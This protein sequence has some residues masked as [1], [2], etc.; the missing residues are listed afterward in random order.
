MVYDIDNK[1]FKEYFI[2]KNHSNMNGIKSIRFNKKSISVTIDKD[3]VNFFFNDFFTKKSL[4]K[5]IIFYL[6]MYIKENQL[7]CFNTVGVVYDIDYLK[8]VFSNGININY[9]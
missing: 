8:Y 7:I 5:D 6:S 4:Y 9:R 1:K 2:E 3:L